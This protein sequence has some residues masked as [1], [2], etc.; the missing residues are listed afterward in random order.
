MWC[1]C[2]GASATR[3]A[4]VTRGG[5]PALRRP[6]VAD[7]RLH[8]LGRCVRSVTWSDGA[9]EGWVGGWVGRGREVVGGVTRDGG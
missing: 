7:E 1:P 4:G 6:C 2:P 9:M 8:P 3:G 5:G